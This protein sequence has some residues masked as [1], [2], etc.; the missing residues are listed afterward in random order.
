MKHHLRNSI[1]KISSYI[2]IY[3]S[4]IILLGV[5]CASIGLVIHL[6]KLV[7]INF[8][9]DFF[10]D[11]LGYA[12]VLIIAV[13][14]IKMLSR[15]TPGS[16][17]EVLVFALARKLIIMEHISALELLMGVIAIGVLLWLRNYVEKSGKEGE[18]LS[19]AI[20]I[21]EVNKIAGINIREEIAQT[22]GGLLYQAIKKKAG[23][24]QEGESILIDGVNFRIKRLRD[25]VIEQVEIVREK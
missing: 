21:K 17:I 12:M 20:S 24:L 6:F 23:T 8:S 19:A 9:P 14:F 5:I 16:T 18:I 22:L 1:S 25:G 3:L 15:H 11:F 7:S 10:R 2:E 4:V 13:E